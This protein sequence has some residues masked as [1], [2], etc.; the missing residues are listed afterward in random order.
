M[1][2]ALNPVTSDMVEALR[3]ISADSVRR[4]EGK[5]CD[6][7]R[8]RSR[9]QDAVL[10]APASTG[11]VSAIVGLCRERTVAIVPF[12]GGTGLVGGQLPHELPRPVVLSLE[13]LNRIRDISTSGNHLT[14]E[15]GCILQDVHAA[16][17]VA[18]RQFP[19]SLASK[20]TCQIGGNL[21][22]NAGGVHVVRYGNARDL[23]LGLE[24]VM[25]DGSIL[26]GLTSLRKDNSGYDL[27]DLFVGSEGTLGIITAA[28]LKLFPQPAETATA[29]L[30]VASPEAALELHFRFRD[31]FGS[32]ISA[33][34]LISRVGFDFQEAT[35][36]EFRWP[37][38]TRPD[39]MVLVD[40]S[41]DAE[42]GIADLL[43]DAA[44]EAME[45][46]LVLDGAFPSSERQRLEL[47]DRREAIPVANRRI[48]A[49]SSHDISVPVDSV[50]EFIE[51]AGIE[52]ANLGDYRVNCFGHMGDG[53]LHYNV[54]PPLRGGKREYGRPEADEVRSAVHSVVSRFRGSLSAEHGTGRHFAD[55]FQRCAD[56]ALIS[57]MR[58]V[59]LALDPTGI[60]NPGAVLTDHR[61][62]ASGR[63][64]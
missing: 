4:Y 27:K 59:K 5:Y 31:R 45:E 19:L 64:G 34:E 60:M 10:V 43:V 15:A 57:A 33:F 36:P 37:L 28:T 44:G 17:G 24:V 35:D 53:N 47:W 55:E 23:C 54:F 1:L 30:A 18:G 63:R 12:G 11:E 7:P 16:A 46:S 25:P 14:A 3:G 22:T 6:D 9:I 20:G 40:L 13:R 32:M 50:A 61:A 62:A 48:G 56:P 38:G 42:I 8:R 2:P 49:V 51:A 26:D 29:L 58:A 39:W 41:A 21:A 52:I